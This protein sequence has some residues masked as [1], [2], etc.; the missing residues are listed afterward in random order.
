M[1][2]GHG[3]LILI[4]NILHRLNHKLDKSIRI[5]GDV[6]TLIGLAV[7]HPVQVATCSLRH[8]ADRN[9]SFGFQALGQAVGEEPEV[10]RGTTATMVMHREIGQHPERLAFRGLNGNHRE[11]IIHRSGRPDVITVQVAR[12]HHSPDGPVTK[13]VELH[14]VRPGDPAAAM[15]ES[16][17]PDLAPSDAGGFQ[18]G[19]S[20]PDALGNLGGQEFGISGVGHGAEAVIHDTR[21]TVGV[22]RGD[23]DPVG[24][25]ARLFRGQ[26]L[27]FVADGPG[28]HATVDDGN[29][30]ARLASLEDEAAGL[31]IPG[32]HLPAPALGEPSA[33]QVRI[34][35]TGHVLHI[36]SGAQGL[37]MNL[38]NGKPTG[39]EGEECEYPDVL[40]AHQSSQGTRR[41]GC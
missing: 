10:I 1:V 28:D 24:R 19:M 23:E 34:K 30:D 41:S 8:C 3:G 17:C 2:H 25:Y 4:A 31:E 27:R 35:G 14:A 32:I 37:P 11:F 9:A 40:N 22:S 20:L 5:A 6:G 18:L 39:K 7:I 33:D 29:R 26:L 12:V 36:G 21:G 38:S 16:G 15:G 13:G